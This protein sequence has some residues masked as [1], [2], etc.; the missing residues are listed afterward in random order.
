MVIWIIMSDTLIGF[1]MIIEHS[2]IA[3]YTTIIS[4][5]VKMNIYNMNKALI[6]NKNISLLF[7]LTLYTLAQ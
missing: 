4:E 1:K 7:T 6:S 3:S 5:Q 2:Y